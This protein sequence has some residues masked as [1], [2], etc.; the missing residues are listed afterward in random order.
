MSRWPIEEIQ[1][2]LEPSLAHLGY[3]VY[4]LERTGVGGKTLRLTIDKSHGFVSIED[5]ERVSHLAGPLLDQSD[6]MPDSYTLEVSSPGAERPLKTPADY[7]R[8]VGRKVNLRYRLGAVEVALEGT[9]GTVDGEGLEVVE[10]RTG[11]I[12]I[13]WADLIAGHLVAS[14]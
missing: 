12:R 6:L 3:S 14:P 1:S 7:E 4:A 11:A 8:F 9:L 10:R 2:L 13:A 5:C